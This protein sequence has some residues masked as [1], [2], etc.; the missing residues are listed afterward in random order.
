LLH[1]RGGD[2]ERFD[3]GT[4]VS[5][6]AAVARLTPSIDPALQWQLLPWDQSST[7]T[8]IPQ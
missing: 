7:A 4:A 6:L 8:G 3:H 1:A 5:R 2:T